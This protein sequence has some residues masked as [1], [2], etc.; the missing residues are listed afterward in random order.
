MISEVQDHANIKQLIENPL[1][2]TAICMLYHDGNELPGQRAELYKK[3]VNN[4]LYKRFRDYEKV[5]SFLTALAFKMH[6]AEMRG[7]GRLDAIQILGEIY[8][9][10]DGEEQRDYKQRLNTA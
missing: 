7:I 5:S 10:K 8:R 1:M 9:Q 6:T 2:L 4:L 3:F